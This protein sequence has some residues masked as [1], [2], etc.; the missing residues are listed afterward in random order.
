MMQYRRRRYDHCVSLCNSL[1]QN[2]IQTSAATYLKYRALSEG[3][4]VWERG[5]ATDAS[6]RLRTQQRHLKRQKADGAE[7]SEPCIT[8]GVSSTAHHHAM[9]KDLTA[10]QPVPPVPWCYQLDAF[11]ATHGH[12]ISS[13]PLH[14]T[15]DIYSFDTEL[16]D[17]DTD[18][19]GRQAGSPPLAKVAC[20]YYIYYEQHIR[21][22]L[23]IC[24]QSLR[25]TGHN[26]WWRSRLGTCYKCLGMMRDAEQQLIDAFRQQQMA[27]T[28]IELSTLYLKSDRPH[29]ALDML[30]E[31]NVTL[32]GEVCMLLAIANICE[33]LCLHEQC[34]ATYKTVIELDASDC[35]VLAAYAGHEFQTENPEVSSRYYRR[36]LQMGSLDFPAW[37]NLGISCLYASQFE[38]SFASLGN[39]IK[40]NGKGVGVWYTIGLIGFAVGDIDFAQKALGLSVSV[41]CS[42]DGL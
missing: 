17:V 7:E 20:D 13:I 37:N 32:S 18:L 19:V 1:L 38:I 16:G 42:R 39:A 24:S 10:P 29:S 9:N 28:L 27:A 3:T 22:A 25:A 2:G 31:G 6:P 41:F 36:L 30:R 11:L 12:L 40:R 34:I 23:D 14:S 4:S 21:F 35:E 26:W 5:E 33:I 15:R 8:Q